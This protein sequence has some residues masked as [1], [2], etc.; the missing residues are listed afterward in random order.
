MASESTIVAILHSPVDDTTGERKRILLQSDTENIVDPTTGKKLSE[1]I[2]DVTYGD[3]SESSSGLMSPT[4]VT[5]IKSLM[6]DT[7]IISETNPG[8]P[9]MWYQIQEEDDDT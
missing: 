9:C 3:A 7:N 2:K 4:Q 1:M 6:S 5:N 8:Q